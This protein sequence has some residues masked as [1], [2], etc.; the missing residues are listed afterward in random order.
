MQDFEKLGQFYLGKEY[1]LSA[2][3][4]TENLLMY[5]SRDLCTHAVVVGMTGSGKTG[6]CIDLLEEAAIDRIP[7]IVIDPKGDIANLMLTFPHLSPEEFR[8]W[9]DEG[10]ASR[11]GVS[12]E[13]FATMEAEKWKTG[14]GSWGQGPERIQKLRDTVEMRIYTPGSSSGRPLTILKSFSAPPS[15]VMQDS[16]ALHDRILSATSGLLAL[17]GIEADP[18]NSREHILISKILETAWREGQ[19]LNLGKLIGQIQMPPFE[20]V[21]I[22]EMDDFYPQK[23]RLQLAMTMNNLL[24]SPSFSSWLEGEPLDIKRMLHTADGKPC[25]SIVSIS[26]LNDEERMFFVTILLNEMI[27]WMRTQSGTSSLRAL[28]YMDEVFG[29]FPPTKNPPSKQPMLTLMKQAR[30][31]GLGCVLATQNPV[32]LDYKGL[33]NAGTWFLG[34]L[35]T[36][37]DKARV[38]EGLEGASA[39]SGSTFNRGKMEK[40][41]AGLGSRRFLMNNVHED[42]PV[43]FETRWAMSYLRGPLTRNQLQEL[44][45][46]DP[47]YDPEAI[48]AA[49]KPSRR[50]AHTESPPKPEPP[51]I[52]PRQLI[53]T[54]VKQYFVEPNEYVSGD[55]RLVYRAALV[56]R[57]RLHYVR[58]TYNC[59]QWKE[60]T[61]LSSVSGGEMPNEIWENSEAVNERLSLSSNPGENPQFDS[62]PE[63]L[64]KSKNFKIWEKEFKEFLYRDHPATIWKCGELKEYSYPNETLG[65]FKVRLEQQVSELRDTEVEALRKKYGK[66]FA[67]LRSKI[68][69]AEDRVEVEKEQYREKK[70]NSRISIGATLLGAIFGRKST[71]SATSSM[72]KLSQTSK[73]KNDIERAEDNLDELQVQFEDLEREFNDEVADLENKLSVDN[74]DYEDRT[75][76]PRKS[77]I[78]IEEFGV[79]WLPLRVTS[80]G[81]AEAI[82]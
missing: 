26:H 61:F 11:K 50:V 54:E 37:R 70:M 76:P 73:E 47:N 14:L 21:G 34:R 30:A 29:F 62:L 66:K 22:M 75:I 46:S 31:F 19:D 68:R 56:G 36:E 9:I 72:R 13:A 8:P 32:D 79:V 52:D 55:D 63:D 28:L 81:I 7:A 59:D 5:D 33:S 1:D 39:Q 44:V 23:D 77:D 25:I 4:R 45:Q 35:Q 67:T 20:R 57:G 60:L 18:I 49:T 38:L 6:L 41:L 71:R 74:L 53:P 16:D 3:E 51:E 43:V 40:V 27:A 12:P 48:A 69:R 82:Y 65:D 10:Q 42:E 64:Q 24:A 15:E 80:S 58:A 17:L 78:L 2:G